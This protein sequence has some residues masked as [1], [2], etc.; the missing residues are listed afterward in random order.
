MKFNEVSGK[1]VTDEEWEWTNKQLYNTS[2]LNLLL[3]LFIYCCAVVLVYFYQVL[4]LDL[5]LLRQRSVGEE[6][7]HSFA[8]LP[9]TE[10]V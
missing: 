1:A 3:F 2:F 5:I 7:D 8:P 9:L 4:G 10:R 6:E